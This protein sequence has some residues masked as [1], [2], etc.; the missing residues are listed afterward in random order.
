MQA[1]LERQ[2]RVQANV[3]LIEARDREER[4]EV[5]RLQ[6][7]G[8]RVASMPTPEGEQLGTEESQAAT[9]WGQEPSPQQMPQKE[10]DLP[11]V[12]TRTDAFEPQSWQ[13]HA[14]RRGN[15]N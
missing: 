4:A 15:N 1:D 7:S 8:S 9:E 5:H 13:P 12:A 3:A 6:V 10:N 11:K 14:R 2:R